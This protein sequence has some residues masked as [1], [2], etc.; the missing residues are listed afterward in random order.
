MSRVTAATACG[1]VRELQDL[2]DATL[3]GHDAHITERDVGGKI[4]VE[5]TDG[6]A[7]PAPIPLFVAGEQ[8]AALWV[9]Y[10]LTVAPETGRIVTETS[11]FRLLL[12]SD[13][14]PIARLEYDSRP[15]TSPV[16]HWHVHAE[17]GAFTALLAKAAVAGQRR[18]DPARLSTVHYP[19]GGAR[20]RPSIEDFLCFLIEECGID[21]RPGWRSTLARGRDRWHQ[22]QARLVAHD[23]A[24]DVAAELRRLGWQ[25]QE[26]PVAAAATPPGVR[27]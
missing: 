16:A 8:V 11:Q 3:P 14:D 9:Q 6:A 5:S 21:S 12:Q 1:M 2:I 24:D 23:H 10:R 4:M 22:V 27:W 25:V 13:R 18:R 26:P 7:R 15:S 19:L 17:R 20:F